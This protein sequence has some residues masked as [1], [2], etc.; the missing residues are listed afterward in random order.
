MCVEASSLPAYTAH[1][2]QLSSCLQPLPSHM[3][4]PTARY[5]CYPSSHRRWA[6]EGT[7]R[8]CRGRSTV[9]VFVNSN[10]DSGNVDGKHIFH[11]R[12]GHCSAAVPQS[13]KG[14][15]PARSRRCRITAHRQP[16]RNSKKKTRLA[17]SSPCTAV[18]RI[19]NPLDH[20]THEV[21]LKIHPGV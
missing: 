16:A 3:P 15:L 21:E 7:N 4:S 8:S 2:A 12:Q 13:C 5:T 9:G 17:C 6:S 11:G 1:A 20:V 18:V 14:P 19:T 10:Y